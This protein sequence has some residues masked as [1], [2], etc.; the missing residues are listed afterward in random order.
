MTLPLTT[1]RV[2][3]AV[4]TAQKWRFESMPWEILEMNAHH[5]REACIK[6]VADALF[7]GYLS[8]TVTVDGEEAIATPK[9]KKGI[10][11]WTSNS[12][13]LKQNPFD[14]RKRSMKRKT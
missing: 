8:L 3:N 6:A 7:K 5:P 11:T 4:K 9:S 14:L 12:L 10:I 2:L 1:K 13:N